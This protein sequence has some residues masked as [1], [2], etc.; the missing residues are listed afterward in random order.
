MRKGQKKFVKNR[1]KS[2]DSDTKCNEKLE[3]KHESPTNDVVW[4]ATTPELLRDAANVP[5]SYPTGVGI[6]I[7]REDS[8]DGADIHGWKGTIPGIMAVHV[9]PCPG[10][11]GGL[12]DPINVAA[13]AMYSFVRHANSGSS[14]Y[15]APDLMIYALAMGQIYSYL[16][17]LIRVY[18]SINLYSHESRYIPRT[19]VEAQGVDYDDLYQHIADFRYGVNALINKAASLAC[20]ADM[21]YFKRL[22]FLFAGIYSEGDTPKDQLYLYVPEGFMVY[23]ET[24]STGGKLTVVDFDSYQDGG[25]LTVAKMLAYGNMLLNPILGSEDMNIM[26]GDILKAYQGNILKLQTLPEVYNIIPVTDLTVLEQMQNATY[27]GDRMPVVAQVVQDPSNGVLTCDVH[28]TINSGYDIWAQLHENIV[29]RRPLTTILVNPEAGDVMERTRLMHTYDY[30]VEGSTPLGRVYASSEVATTVTYYTMAAGSGKYSS[31]RVN[32]EQNYLSSDSFSLVNAT[33]YEQLVQQ[34]S[35]HC[36]MENFKFHP[37]VAYYSAIPATDG[38]NTQYY[39]ASIALDFDNYTLLDSSTVERINEA[40]ALALFHVPS[41][42][43]F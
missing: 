17:F 38:G 39:L 3:C 13:T 41:I 23:S 30:V 24:G 11:E 21:T 28:H 16:N 34:V 26:S 9:L 15:N 1:N 40:A 5:F 14:N 35:A 8:Y 32:M 36:T 33:S 4:Y 2:K 18:G 25:K 22:A 19:L 27:L 6:T 37:L 20:P 12:A 43:K 7:G 31:R 29:S 10:T 42:G